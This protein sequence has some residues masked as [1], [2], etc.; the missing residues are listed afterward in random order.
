VSALQ[1]LCVHVMPNELDPI[2]TSKLDIAVGGAS[3]TAEINGP[4]PHYGHAPGPNAAPPTGEFSADWYNKV[5]N[6]PRPPG[7]SLP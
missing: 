2:R 3:P 1:L 7:V 4:I 5:A 6:T